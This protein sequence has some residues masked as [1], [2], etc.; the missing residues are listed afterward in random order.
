MSDLASHA[1]FHA[2]EP[3]VRRITIADVTASLA[4]GWRDFLETPTQLFFLALIYPVVGL[5]LGYVTAGR[6]LLTIVWPLVAGFALVGPIAALGIYEMSRRREQGL[7]VSVWNGM[8]VFRSA[9]LG[10]II[11]VGLVLLLLLA[12][13]LLAAEWIFRST[14]GADHPASL[15]DLWRVA[16]GTPEGYRLILIGNVVG[17]VFAVAALAVSVVS[18]PLLLERDVGTV[19]AIRTSIRAV[20]T[21][22]VPM[23]VWG[24]IVAGLLV[25]GS[26]PVLV[27]LAIVIPVLG[28]STW[29]LYRRTL[30]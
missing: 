13:W 3:Q 2:A 24:L 30:G 18:L 28:H 15:G 23:A 9:G 16:T 1:S 19:A 29:H 20:A 11:G 12:A 4:Q 22:P 8:D 26:L 14:I 21:N 7:P 17:F 5:A 10:S 6:D 27:G 25:L